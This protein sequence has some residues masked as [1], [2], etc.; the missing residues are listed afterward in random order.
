[1]DV[2][3]IV[4]IVAVVLAGLASL[5]VAGKWLLQ[6][7]VDIGATK[8]A[9]IT[10][11]I[12]S[13]INGAAMV[14]KGAGLEKVGVILEEFADIPDELGDV[15]TKIAE[16]TKNQDFTKERFLE[17]YSEGKDVVVEAKDFFIKVIKKQ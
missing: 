6:K 11:K 16:M 7:G 12:A 3:E 10:E 15:G 14:A 5:T 17:L 1:M 13:S 2:L 4:K 8:A 9:D